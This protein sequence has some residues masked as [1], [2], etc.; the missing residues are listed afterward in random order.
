MRRGLDRVEDRGKSWHENRELWLTETKPTLVGG[1]TD[2]SW[3][4]VIYPKYSKHSNKLLSTAMWVDKRWAD[5]W[6][7]DFTL[8]NPQI[9]RYITISVIILKNFKSTDD[10][11]LLKKTWRLKKVTH[12]LSKNF[13]LSA[14]LSAK[15]I[16]YLRYITLGWIADVRVPSFAPQKALISGRKFCIDVANDA[17]RISVDMRF[18][19]QNMVFNEAFKV[20]KKRTRA[21][22]LR[23]D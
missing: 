5:F 18:H 23:A 7:L 19:G 17:K 14:K 3:I 9:L 1:R 6:Q 15:S 22:W 2:Q 20:D 16:Y 12:D 10:S 13:I 11:F 4:K 8:N 21:A